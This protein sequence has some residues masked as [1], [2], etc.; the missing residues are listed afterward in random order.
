MIFLILFFLCGT[1]QAAETLVR[2]EEA[3][4]KVSQNEKDYV[5][6]YI[7]AYVCTDP[8][9]PLEDLQCPIPH[10]DRVK[11]YTGIQ[12][13]Y[14]SIE[15]LGRWAEEPKLVNPP[16]TSRPDCKGYSGPS[17]AAEILTKIGVKFEQT[18][19]D[20]D[21][22]IRLIKKSMREGRG[23][24]W[25]V[26]GHAM[27]LVHYDDI[28]NKVCWV[29]NS[30]SSLKVQQTTI[31][32]FNKRW[33]SWVLA[34]YAD[35]DIVIQKTRKYNFPILDA[36]EPSKKFPRNFVPFPQFVN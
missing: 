1:V 33:G 10:K 27:V 31:D 14:S 30:D 7:P 3:P 21:K 18:Y 9:T 16:L 13:V 11:N 28:A 34:I 36:L 12:C 5:N 26:P 15:M 4:L 23:V 19:G 2:Y 6:K 25:D 17:R 8:D 22:G 32:K 24:L 35:E 20:R 29:D